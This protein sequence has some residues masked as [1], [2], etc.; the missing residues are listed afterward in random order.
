MAVGR[1]IDTFLLDFLQA[2]QAVETRFFHGLSLSLVSA[3]WWFSFP[4]LERL[5]AS[6]ENDRAG[7]VPGPGPESW[8][9]LMSSVC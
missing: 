2:R 3:A 6:G 4:G 1:V 9:S 7:P 8:V 5:P